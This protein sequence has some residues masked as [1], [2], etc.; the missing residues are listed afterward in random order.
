[1]PVGFY[2]KA[3]YSDGSSIVEIDESGNYLNKYSDI[4]R[5]RLS[6]FELYKSNVLLFRL[7]LIEGRRLIYRRRVS[8]SLVTGTDSVVYLIG[9]QQTINGK[10][11]Q[12]IAYIFEDGRV[13]LSGKWDTNNPV[14]HAPNLIECEQ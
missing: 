2:W 1:M 3:V 12:D 8:K 9:W 13:E 7:H 4:D 10:N 11:I 14:F 6:Y 5:S